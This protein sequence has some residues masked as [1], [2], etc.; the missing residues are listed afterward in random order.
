MKL[1]HLWILFVAAIISVCVLCVEC[2]SAQGNTAVLANKIV[3]ELACGKYSNV[4]EHFDST[5][6][7]ELPADKLKMVW[8]SI[9][10][11][12]GPYQ[13]RTSIKVECESKY[14]TAYV[15]IKFQKLDADVKVVFNSDQ[16]VSGFF[17][18]PRGENSEYAA[19]SYA[20]LGCFCEK[21][22]S[23]GS[24]E[25]VLPGTL[26]VPKGKGPF[27]AVVLVQGSGPEDRDESICQ[28]KP[29]RDI[30]LGLASN[31]IAVLRYDKR[32]YVYT[33]KTAAVQNFTVNDETIEDA[34][35]AVKLLMNTSGIDHRKIFVLGHSLGGMLAPRIA[36]W[37]SKIAG[38]IILAGIARPLE[39]VTLD[40]TE[41]ISSIGGKITNE[42]KE[43]IDSM[44][45]QVSRVKDPNLS[46]KSPGTILGAPPSYWLDL[47]CYNAPKCAQSLCMPMF[48]LQG[49]RDYQVTTK[50]YDLWK[51]YLF[52]KKSV[53]FKLYPC[54]NHL[55][56]FGK[57]KSIPVEY[58][59]LS[60]VDV[61]V[62]NDVA[63]WVKAH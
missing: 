58:E 55:F 16:E 17:I 38:I 36:S 62:I 3:D 32:T 39:D 37:N 59:L 53:Q 63:C 47:R 33:D 7:C 45:Y 51:K 1:Y 6:K 48:I 15:G 41:Y 12:A 5:M 22:V 30:A 26:T 4:V 61:Q 24:G 56:M 43:N 29:F 14:E 40:Q 20:K 31:G 57:G 46:P 25:W 28:N 2:A 8:T 18:V 21:E 10:A 49:K 50:D 27:P 35:A 42:Q 13:K 23:V 44:K 19:P 54:L 34:L 52:M 60:H 9:L 11:Q